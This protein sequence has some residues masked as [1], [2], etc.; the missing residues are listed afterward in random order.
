MVD[1]KDFVEPGWM[2]RLSDIDIQSLRPQKD[3]DSDNIYWL[4]FQ[5]ETPQSDNL[6]QGAYFPGMQKRFFDSKSQSP[7]TLK[8]LETDWEN[9]RI[10]VE[11]KD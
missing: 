8:V 1:S 4:H 2:G 11:L 6:T 7:G 5:H 9:F 10:K 3:P